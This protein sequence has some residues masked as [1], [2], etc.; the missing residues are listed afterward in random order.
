M[1][2]PSYI[3]YQLGNP[4]NPT[5][6]LS[7]VGQSFFGAFIIFD[8]ICRIYI[9]KAFILTTVPL[10]FNNFPIAHLE[11]WPHT[12]IETI[13]LAQSELHS[14]VYASILFL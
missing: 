10:N 13:N 7:Q 9:S 12:Q 5:G 11:F 3:E 1:N 6:F 4:P 8:L 2:C 14:L